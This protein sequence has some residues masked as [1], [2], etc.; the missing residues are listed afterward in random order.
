MKNYTTL[1]TA[2]FLGG[3]LTLGGYK[4]FID[5]HD[6]KQEALE[7]LSRPAIVQ[8]NHTTPERAMTG[9]TLWKLLTRP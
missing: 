1:I 8:T 9:L 5:K 7:L 4:L 6:A 3:V 2:A